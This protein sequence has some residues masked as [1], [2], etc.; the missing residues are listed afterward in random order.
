MA[1]VGAA[2][3]HGPLAAATSPNLVARGFDVAGSY[4]KGE[5]VNAS[6]A[7]QYDVSV[8]IRA[9][10]KNEQTTYWQHTEKLGDLDPGES[11]SIRVRYGEDVPRPDALHFDYQTGAKK[12]AT[13]ARTKL[14]TLSGKDQGH[15]EWF[16]L[17]EGDVSFEYSYEAARN[18]TASIV[19]E[20]ESG[21]EKLVI[22]EQ[23]VAATATHRGA[24]THVVFTE[25]RYRINVRS[26]GPWTMDVIQGRV[27]Q[28]SR[29]EGPE[30]KNGKQPAP[31]SSISI[32]EDESGVLIITR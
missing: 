11:V 5:I 20:D 30:A 19:L 23:E 4:L 24:K 13:P 14:F 31:P 27:P 16:T 6:D 18:G 9:M 10:S 17:P 12:P 22:L 8:T 2:L 25:G 28:Y 26:Q 1:L 3:V 15:S 7:A 29:A 32:H 21:S